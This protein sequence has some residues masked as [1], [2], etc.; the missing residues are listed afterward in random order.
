MLITLPPRVRAW[1]YLV[2]A[3]AGVALAS[4]QAACLAL[5]GQPVWLTAAWAAYGPVA[6]AVTT[7]AQSNV[8]D[9]EPR[10]ALEEAPPVNA[11][12][13]LVAY[14]EIPAADDPTQ[15]LGYRQKGI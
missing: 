5:G 6:A 11:D 8:P 14:S 3:V 10:R 7:L 2:T 15:V 9:P 1:V 13:P 4:A 12:P